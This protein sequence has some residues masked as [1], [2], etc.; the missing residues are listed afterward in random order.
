VAWKRRS[1]RTRTSRPP[2][3]GEEGGRGNVGRGRVVKWACGSFILHYSPPQVGGLFP[4]GP[5]PFDFP[6]CLGG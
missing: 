4:F 1:W 5:G 3:S 6:F 2:L